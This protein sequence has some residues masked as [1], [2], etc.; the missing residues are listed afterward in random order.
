M[1]RRVRSKTYQL[2][3]KGRSCESSKFSEFSPRVWQP[4]LRVELP[5][6]RNIAEP[7]S[8]RWPARL[9]CSGFVALRYPTRPG[10]LRVCRRTPRSSARR[11]ARSLNQTIARPIRRPKVRSSQRC[12]RFGV[13]IRT[14]TSRVFRFAC[15]IVRNFRI[16]RLQHTSTHSAATSSAMRSGAIRTALCVEPA[17]GTTRS[18][19]F[20]E[21]SQ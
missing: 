1:N 7:C 11:V 18:N 13:A 6:R 4:R 19:A 17:A 10:S 21:M 3:R 2:K 9:M 20:S 15:R 12:R 5:W 8:S 14:N 16:I